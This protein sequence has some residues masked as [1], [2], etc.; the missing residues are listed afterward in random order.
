MDPRVGLSEAIGAYDEYLWAGGGGGGGESS[1]ECVDAMR[2]SVELRLSQLFS[3]GS[4]SSLESIL[5]GFAWNVRFSERSERPAIS[6]GIS[7]VCLW[8][9][10]LNMSS[11]KPPKSKSPSSLGGTAVLA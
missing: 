4:T 1:S 9:K 7:G 11:S 5:M 8:S 2:L 10:W 3:G 6:R